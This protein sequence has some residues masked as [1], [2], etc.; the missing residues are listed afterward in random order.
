MKT[1]WIW[2]SYPSAYHSGHSTQSSPST[3]MYCA[4]WPKL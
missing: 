2:T 1:L 4:K 3:W